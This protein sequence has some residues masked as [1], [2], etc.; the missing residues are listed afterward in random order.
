MIKFL[1]LLVLTIFIL[2]NVLYGS[3][4][5]ITE[6]MYDV[7]GTDSGNEWIEVLNTSENSIDLTTY[8]FFEN[9]T[10]HIITNLNSSSLLSTGQYAII[11]DNA[12]N[13]KIKFPN[14]PT[15]NIYDS[16]FSLT[17]SLGEYLAIK[18][19]E[20]D[21]I[22]EIT[23]DPAV[24]ASGDGNSLYIDSANFVIAGVPSPLGNISENNGNTG[25]SSNTSTNS[26][27]GTTSST[28]G[29]STTLPKI[30][31]KF[32]F[33]SP[34]IIV[35]NNPVTIKAVLYG[36]SGEMIDRGEFTWNFGDGTSAIVNHLVPIDHTYFYPG[37]Y[38]VSISYRYSS[39][40]P[41]IFLNKL[42]ITVIE[43]PFELVDLYSQPVSAVGI[44]NN[45]DA[46]YDIGSYMIRTGNSVITLPKNTF[47]SGGD[48]V[49]ITL[50]KNNYIKNEIELLDPMGNTVSKFETP[51]VKESLTANVYSGVRYSNLN[52]QD[53]ITSNLSDNITNADGQP[54]IIEI[55]QDNE[56]YS[57]VTKNNSYY[58]LVFVITLAIVIVVYI[59]KKISSK[60]DE[61]SSDDYTLQDE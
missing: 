9:N 54:K 20:G 8:K 58:M 34:S 57:S 48:Q 21:I 22:H 45:R 23:Y 42:N 18:N 2:P 6:I 13:F 61:V 15:S 60:K 11:A 24:G 26:T 44:K 10:A 46:E 52:T 16:V 19:S 47:V 31:S 7:S 55:T 27:S 49:Y 40:S 33:M 32:V 43:S 30:T 3:D 53:Y 4:I 12:E 36:S 5:R 25:N 41:I 51:I 38:V 1:R 50:P 39:Y 29:G 37:N 28:G 56:E 59:N 17:N 14:L 35:V